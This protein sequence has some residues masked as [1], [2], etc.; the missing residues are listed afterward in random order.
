MTE[1]KFKIKQQTVDSSLTLDFNIDTENEQYIL[2]CALKFNDIAILLTDNITYR[3]FLITN[4]IAIAWCIQTAIERQLEVTPEILHILI[5]EYDGNKESTGLKYVYEL[6]N[7]QEVKPTV[8]NFINHIHKL[9]RDKIKYTIYYNHINTLIKDLKNPHADINKIVGKIDNIRNYIEI[10]DNTSDKSFYSLFDLK[11]EHDKEILNRESGGQFQSIGY[12]A[13][14]EYLTEGLATKQISIVAGRPGMCKSAFVDNVILRLAKTGVPCA[15]FSLEMRRI[16]AYDRF[17]SIET[18]IPLTILLRDRVLMTEAQK[19]SEATNKFKMSKYPIYVYDK[20]APTLENI[21]RQL[22]N[23]KERYG[24]KIAVFDLFNKVQK[25]E[26]LKH[27]STAD[28]IFYML[29]YMQ[30]LAKNLDVHICLVVQIGRRAEMRKGKKPQLSDL[31]DSGAYE[32]IADLVLLLYR[33]SYYL[34]NENDRNIYFNNTSGR[35]ILEVHLG[36]Q[37]QGE[38]NAMIQLEFKPELTKIV[39]L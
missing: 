27:K 29:D 14:N 2:A 9:K 18:N 39:Q 4:H 20:A 25:P 38:Q 30:Q 23:A 22:K 11:L 19:Q 13:I 12:R 5:N 35:D 7:S 1:S 16:A 6:I 32:E 10:S 21:A 8:E 33:E 31:K 37:R 15:L 24:I 34:T 17:L 3:D 28:Q 26:H 36:K